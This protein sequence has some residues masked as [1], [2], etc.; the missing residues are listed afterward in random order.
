M[1]GNNLK[2]VFRSN[3]FIYIKFEIMYSYA[4]GAVKQ[5]VEYMKL[6]FRERPGLEV[7]MVG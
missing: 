4:W 1:E 3:G 5:S 7:Y 6:E 2:W